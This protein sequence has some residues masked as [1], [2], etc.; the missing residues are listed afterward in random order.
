M[1]WP[2]KEGRDLENSMK[3]KSG[4]LGQNG[5]SGMDNTSVTMLRIANRITKDILK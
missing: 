1:G 2:L 3:G 5:L 4:I